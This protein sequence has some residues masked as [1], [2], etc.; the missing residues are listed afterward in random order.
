MNK[1]VLFILFAILMM[2]VITVSVSADQD[3]HYNWCNIDQYGC[4]VTG[5]DGAQNYIMFWSEEARLYFMGNST[6]PYKNVV[7]RCVDC[8]GG[9]LPLPNS[10]PNLICSKNGRCRTSASIQ[11]EIGYCTQAGYINC[12]WS[13]VTGGIIAD[14]KREEANK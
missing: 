8:E 5:D 4:W 10:S 3:G 9:K 1:K 7:D 13:D 11:R 2:A 12:R 6:A 14:G